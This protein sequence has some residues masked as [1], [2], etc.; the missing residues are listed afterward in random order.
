MKSNSYRRDQRVQRPCTPLAVLL[1]IALCIGSVSAINTWQIETVDADGW[2]GQFSSLAL[3]PISRYPRISYW[4]DAPT[5]SDLKYAAWD[6][7]AWQIETVDSAGDTGLHTSLAL[8]PTTGY[9]R[10]SYW[11]QT[12]NA[13]KYAAW[14]GAAWQ[15]ETVESESGYTTYYYMSLALDSAGN[16]RISYQYV[17]SP[18]HE[19]RYAAWDG[20][21]WQIETVDSGDGAGRDCSL[22]LDPGTGYPRI[23][24]CEW[25]TDVTLKYAAWDGTAWQI[26]TVDDAGDV[27]EHT[28]LALDPGTGYPRISYWD[29]TG[30]NLKFAAWDGAAWQIETVDGVGNVGKYTSLAL[31]PATGYPRISYFDQTNYYLKYAAWDGAAWQIETADDAENVGEDTSLAVDPITG[32]PRISYFAFGSNGDLK[33]AKG[34]RANPLHVEKEGPVWAEKGDALT[35]T[36]LVTNTGTVGITDVS[37]ED[38]TCSPVGYVAGDAVDDTLDPGEEW[39]YEC[40][41]TPNPASF[42][43]AAYINNTVTATGQYDSSQ[44][45]ASDSYYLRAAIVRKNVYLYQTKDPKCNC[46]HC[47]YG[48]QYTPPAENPLPYFPVYLQ[49]G[50]MDVGTT[51]I[52]GWNTNPSWLNDPAELWLSEGTWKA[53]ERATDL[54]DG[55]EILCAGKTWTI[56]P[57]NTGGWNDITFTNIIHYDLAVEKSGPDY[58]HPGETITYSYLVTNA[59]PAS[60]SP[61]VTDDTCSP[62][63]YV[64]G[65]ANGNCRIDPGEE[66]TFECEYTVPADTPVDTELVN[67]ACVAD[68]NEPAEY[69]MGGDAN[70]CNNCDDWSVTILPWSKVTTSDLCEFDTDTGTEG[71]QF[72]LIFTPDYPSGNGVYK[73]SASNPGQF[74]YNVF[75]TGEAGDEETFTIELPTPFITKGARPIHAYSDVIVAGDCYTAVNEIPF[76]CN[77]VGNTITVDA[78]VPEGGLIYLTV[79]LDFGWKKETMYRKSGNDAIYH[80][81]IPGVDNILDLHSYDFTVTDTDEADA[82]TI[83]NGNVFKRDPGFAGFVFDAD[84]EPVAG[85]TLTITDPNGE[86]F[87]TVET[88]DDGFYFYYYKHTGKEQTW[89]LSA[90]GQVA[91]VAL[92]ANK[93]VQ[94]DFWI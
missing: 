34:I 22:A 82:Q 67:E 46:Y 93:L 56:D 52:Y 51:S 31:D 87:A 57:E 85:A 54:P 42:N 71:Q 23:S 36:Y 73:L 8:D 47:Y 86:V 20:A 79:H 63:T 29:A 66:W 88:N 13:V 59:G 69:R 2:T 3:D 30:D 49:K 15:I 75:F 89:T 90:G 43:P 9:P 33:F 7:A 37:V 6:G 60:V 16:P 32:D 19:L 62:V 24:Y 53:E 39:T 50:G 83:Q 81:D 94:T 70:L 77:I 17:H 58:A 21:A 26:E 61:E 91:S 78:T 25:P 72:R 12:T 65:D 64:D 40:T 11:D 14:D 44:V 68:A 74:Y 10:I 48:V 38:D 80:G 18:A 28:S 76:T 84:G 1:L 27:G 45:S 5:R 4:D 35:Y 41:F 92:K 55:F